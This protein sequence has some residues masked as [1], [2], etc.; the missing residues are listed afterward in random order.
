MDDQQ[1][2]HLLVV[3]DDKLNQMLM[4]Q[5]LKKEGHQVTFAD[6]GKQAL[7]LLHQ[8]HFDM[9]LLDIEMP[10][11]NG[12]EVLQHIILDPQLLDIPVIVT[13][14]LDQLDSV[15]RCIEMGAE[16]YLT[17]PVN[18][19]L[20]KARIDASLEKKHLRDKQKATVK[21]LEHEM[22]LARITQM[23]LLPEKLPDPPGYAFGALMIPAISVGGDFYDIIPMKNNCWGL[24]VG[25]VAG[26]GLTAALYMTLAY[27]LLRVEALIENSPA[28]ALIN[29]NRYLLEMNTS[30]MF[31]TVLCGILDCNNNL[32]SYARAGH[33][34]PLVITPSGKIQKP[35]M[36]PSQ[37]I[38]LFEP[39]VLDE[40][41]IIIEDHSSLILL[42]DGVSEPVNQDNE[43]FD[44]QQLSNFLSKNHEANPQELCGKLWEEVQIHSGNYPQQDDFTV[45]AVRFSRS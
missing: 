22:A 36:K 31:V 37:A 10:V 19:I 29:V 4:G 15:V 6:N 24:V 34:A 1:M 28:Q 2:S 16:D 43:Q 38:G 42:S 32:F 21:R 41:Q 9:I 18:R 27:S 44:E 20:L 35:P 26:K 13:S 3:E 30:S 14:A 5:Y 11:M 17:K 39:L 40:G 33:L 12:Y 45:L 7:E 23:S 8:A 25:D